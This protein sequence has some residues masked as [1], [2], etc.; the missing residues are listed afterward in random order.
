MKNIE[1]MKL[2]TD[3]D[4]KKFMEELLV[5]IDKKQKEGYD[6]EVQYASI[7][8]CFTCLVICRA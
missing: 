2:I 1:F 7:E 4:G 6:V 5:Y 8:S 3:S